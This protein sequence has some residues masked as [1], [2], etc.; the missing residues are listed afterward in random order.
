MS[1][2]LRILFWSTFSCCR[3]QIAAT[4]TAYYGGEHVI[5]EVGG[6]VSNPLPQLASQVMEEIGM[7]IEETREP[8][9]T[10]FSFFRA[11]IVILLCQPD[12][13]GYPILPAGIEYQV[14]EVGDPCGLEEQTLSHLRTVRNTIDTYVRTL[15]REKKIHV[16]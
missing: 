13:E 6:Q 15:L 3:S 1:A 16:D 5:A 14:W 9:M 10:L 8:F 7:D 11:D 12:L 2:P 4:I